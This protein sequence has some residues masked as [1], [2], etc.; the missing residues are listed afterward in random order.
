MRTEQE[1][2]E[3]TDAT[4]RQ[5]LSEAR[6]IAVVGL[7]EN[8]EQPAYRVAHYLQ[9]QGYQIVPVNPHAT[10][11]L[12]EQAYPNVT[13]I[14]FAVDIVDIF[15]PANEVGPSVEEAVQKHARVVWMQQGIRN[16]AAAWYA[17]N[18]GLQVVMNHCI[19][20]EHQRLLGSAV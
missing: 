7:S 8:D 2:F 20:Q 4:L 17:H 1:I 10:T 13:S 18:A 11:V 9:Q 16:A 19:H 12:G 5:I 15:R 3:V 6:I 14:P